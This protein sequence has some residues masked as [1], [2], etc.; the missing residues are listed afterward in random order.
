MGLFDRFK[1]VYGHND[2]TL[3][4]L[5]SLF[6]LERTSKP[7][8]HEM[9]LWL[10]SVYAY[11]FSV[12]WEVI[13][14]VSN[15]RKAPSCLESEI[16]TLIAD[17]ANHAQYWID[18]CLE[19]ATKQIHGAPRIHFELGTDM[20]RSRLNSYFDIALDAVDQRGYSL[21]LARSH[22][23]WVILTQCAEQEMTLDT[24]SRQVSVE[25]T[26]KHTIQAFETCERLAQEIADTIKRQAK[27]T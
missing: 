16:N 11:L 27:R 20:I 1:R 8:P 17:L 25:D 21:S 24:G 6:V 19:E 2:D 4:E 7:R 23:C 5:V 12:A 18:G 10:E 14:L 3:G 15:A 22:S 26:A 13:F 9:D